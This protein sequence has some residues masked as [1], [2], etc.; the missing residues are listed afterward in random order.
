M[1]EGQASGGEITKGKVVS[2]RGGEKQMGSFSGSAFFEQKYAKIAKG[3][4]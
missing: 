3:L 1:R 2:S 4:I